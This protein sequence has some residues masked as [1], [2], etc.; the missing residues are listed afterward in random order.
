MSPP[1]TFLLFVSVS[2]LSLPLTCGVGTD[3]SSSTEA[4]ALGGQQRVTVTDEAS[5]DTIENHPGPESEIP[6]D[7]GKNTDRPVEDKASVLRAEH[8]HCVVD[9][10][11]NCDAGGGMSQL[12]K[13]KEVVDA[14]LKDTK[15]SQEQLSADEIEKKL[16]KYHAMIKWVEKHG[17]FG[18]H[19]SFWYSPK[20][21][22]GVIASEDIKVT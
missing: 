9:M 5:K 14:T 19:I 17:G 10:G 11:G 15:E 13:E 1:T 2:I 3:G 21:G 18:R 20:T 6:P 16:E 12:L 4:A 8:D 22:V 7:Q